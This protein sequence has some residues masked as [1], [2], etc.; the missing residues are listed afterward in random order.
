MTV[1]HLKIAFLSSLCLFFLS[2]RRIESFEASSIGRIQCYTSQFPCSSSATF[3]PSSLTVLDAKKNQK[4]K[5]SPSVEEED[6][7]KP[8]GLRLVLVFLTPWLNPNSIFLY[9][10]LTVFL[11]GKYSEA[12]S[13]AN[14]SGAM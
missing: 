4:N 12:Q 1:R 10:F 11:L 5:M 9:L 3:S 2:T 8:R 14:S 7:D 6:K 13:I